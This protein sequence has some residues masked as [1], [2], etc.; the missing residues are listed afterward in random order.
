MENVE[1][2]GDRSKDTSNQPVPTLSK[3]INAVPARARRKS[4]SQA[5]G[6]VIDGS[7]NAA[8]A[9]NTNLASESTHKKGMQSSSLP[10]DI[11]K[12]PPI[13]KD[14]DA[15]IDNSGNLSKSCP[16]LYSER[17]MHH[18]SRS[19][20]S[21][22]QHDRLQATASASSANAHDDIEPP[23]SSADTAS[24]RR[25]PVDRQERVPRNPIRDDCEENS[26]DSGERPGE[27]SAVS[28][29][30]FLQSIPAP[31]PEEPSTPMSI[32]SSFQ[33]NSAPHHERQKSGTFTNNIPGTRRM[34]RSMSVSVN[35]PLKL[36]SKKS[37]RRLQR[38]APDE[39]SLSGSPNN[40]PDFMRPPST[41]ASVTPSIS[42]TNASAKQK[43]RSRPSFLSFITRTPKLGSFSSHGTLK[44]G[45]LEP[46][47][48]RDSPY[49]AAV[50]PNV[51][52]ASRHSATLQ[53]GG[54]S[55][56]LDRNFSQTSSLKGS[57]FFHDRDSPYGADEPIGRSRGHDQASRRG[58][59]SS[60]RH[61]GNADRDSPYGAGV[62]VTAQGL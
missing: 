34:S 45:R 16:I 60:R 22:M 36:K 3:L 20:P 14:D 59:K 19:S 56:Y 48:D 49:G 39:P 9:S 1:V 4:H 42:T 50:M 6:S 30:D 44:N 24:T 62:Q 26:L 29:S 15:S 47:I 12:P 53:R 21:T 33:E 2:E 55:P 17:A 37:R 57:S 52:Y 25:S 51:A 40:E 27:H 46:E 54:N 35:P 58:K 28:L 13:P 38:N 32:A 31:A 23:S 43:P 10:V 61:E 18:A 7:Q 8:T 11:S 41:S 5:R